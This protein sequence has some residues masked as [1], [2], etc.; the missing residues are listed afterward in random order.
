MNIERKLNENFEVI[1]IVSKDYRIL[2]IITFYKKLDNPYVITNSKNLFYYFYRPEKC[3]FSLEVEFVSSVVD[4]FYYSND[5]EV[6]FNSY[7]VDTL[8]T[9]NKINKVLESFDPEILG[10]KREKSL[11]LIDKYYEEIYDRFE[12]IKKI[13]I[14]N[15]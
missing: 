15:N 9:N 3:N 1:S 12:E 13:I 6:N 7:Y 10:E 5:Y 4:N 11:E 2:E 14:N 8:E